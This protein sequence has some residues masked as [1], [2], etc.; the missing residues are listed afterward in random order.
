MRQ[1]G[2]GANGSGNAKKLRLLGRLWKS[3]LVE[4]STGRKSN[5]LFLRAR[6]ADWKIN[7]ARMESASASIHTGKTLKNQVDASGRPNGEPSFFLRHGK[8]VCLQK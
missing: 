2:K 3:S 5:A 7:E 1:S 8:T 4:A 6:K